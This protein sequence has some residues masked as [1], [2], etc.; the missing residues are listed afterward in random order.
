MH[1]LPAGGRW[2]DGDITGRP[3]GRVQELARI[4]R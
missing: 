1:Q 3:A 2:P 4:D